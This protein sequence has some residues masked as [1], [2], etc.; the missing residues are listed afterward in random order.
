MALYRTNCPNGSCSCIGPM[1]GNPS[2]GYVK[3]HFAELNK[4][5]NVG[6]DYE[7]LLLRCPKCKH[8]WRARPNTV[9]PW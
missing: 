3:P 1:E 4:K 6:G 7:Q 2:G 5:R 9:H 8:R